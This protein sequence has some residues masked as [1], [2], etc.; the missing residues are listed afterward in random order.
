VPTG[1]R[2]PGGRR[3]SPPAAIRLYSVYALPIVMPLRG[4]SWPLERELGE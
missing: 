4:E 1:S 3:E 2:D